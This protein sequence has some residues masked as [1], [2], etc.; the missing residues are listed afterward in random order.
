MSTGDRIAVSWPNDVDVVLAYHGAMRLGAVWV[1]VNQALAPPEKRWQLADSGASLFLTDTALDDAGVPILDT[2][3]W[4]SAVDAAADGPIGVEVDRYAP[5][6]FAYTSGTT[7]RPKGAVHSQHN[8]LLPGD[9]AGGDEGV[10]PGAPQG[11]L[12]R[13]HH[14]QHDGAHH[15]AGL[16]GRGHVDPHG[17]HRRRGSGRVDP[18]RAG[19]DLERP[20]GPAVQPGP[21]GPDRRRPTWPASTRSGPAAPTAPKPSARPSSPS[22]GCR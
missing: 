5:A 21:H 1:G 10:R 8:L 11:G 19:H 18:H 14:P 15:P 17:P 20:T 3:A 22:S 4:R 13:L 6:G 16:P 2:S 9:G 7:G 12:L